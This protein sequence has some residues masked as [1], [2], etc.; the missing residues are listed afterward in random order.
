MGSSCGAR[1]LV[2]YLTND[3]HADMWCTRRIPWCLTFCGSRTIKIAGRR[4]PTYTSDR[5]T[6]ISV[7]G[8]RRRYTSPL[9]HLTGLRHCGT[10]RLA[11]LFG[12]GRSVRYLT[13]ARTQPW[14]SVA[15]E[16]L[17]FDGAPASALFCRKNSRHACGNELFRGD[18]EDVS[19]PMT[20]VRQ[21]SAGRKHC[22]KD[23]PCR[24]GLAPRAYRTPARFG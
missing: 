15:G 7:Q 23:L 20:E 3:L 18:I 24:P 2:R 11:A 6:T 10:R 8:D 17:A 5:S 16:V 19:A 14:R 22:C 9:R 1:F 13:K 4:A 12:L 21:P